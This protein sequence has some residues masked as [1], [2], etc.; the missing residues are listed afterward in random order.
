MIS[1]GLLLTIAGGI[2][3]VV[4]IISL[5][6]NHRSYKKRI[7]NLLEEIENE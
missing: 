1:T 2:G 3:I 5:I 4:C 7:K 6:V